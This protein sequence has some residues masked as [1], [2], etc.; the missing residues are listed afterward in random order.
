MMQE[1]GMTRVSPAWDNG[2]AAII[3]GHGKRAL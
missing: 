3:I 1:V 2:H